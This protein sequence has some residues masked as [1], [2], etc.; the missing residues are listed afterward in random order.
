M[1]IVVVKV[2]RFNGGISDDV[3][4]QLNGVFTITRNFDIFSNKTR[5]T[6]YRDT[7]AADT[8]DGTS[9]TMTEFKT[10]NFGYDSSKLFAL[11]R[12]SSGSAL[13][14]ILE[15]SVPSGNWSLSGS[16]SQTTNGV[17][18]RQCFFPYRNYFY[19]L[20][21]SGAGTSQRADVWRYGSVASGARVLELTFGGADVLT[22]NDSSLSR[23]AQGFIG[24]D[25]NAYLPYE[26]KLARTNGTTVTAAVLTLPRDLT[27]KSGTNWSRYAALACAPGNGNDSSKIFFWDFVSDDVTDVVDVGRG[28]LNVLENIE[29]TLIG[30][31]DV[32]GTT[33]ISFERKIQIIA[34]SGGSPRV[35]H[36]KSYTAAF[37]V[38]IFKQKKGNKL[39]IVLYDGSTYGIYV[40][41]RR[42]ANSPIAVTFDRFISND[43]A[44]TAALNF[45]FVGD[46]LFAST[47]TSG[48][49]RQ[50]LNS[51]T[52]TATSVYES[53][54]LNAGEI[55]KLKQLKSVSL[56][57]VPLPAGAVI[58]LDVKVD[59]GS[60]KEVFS[61][62]TDGRYY[63][64]A[65]KLETTNREFDDGYEFEFRIKSTGLAEP[66]EFKP[67]FEVLDD[68]QEE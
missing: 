33:S 48:N 11:G 29:G 50:T 22:I 32:G 10:E 9:S 57:F 59:G 25:D 19:G 55:T 41:G 34:W 42:D 13:L 30:V 14:R 17:P 56:G 52:F 44:V 23:A 5:L 47:G 63:H 40:I 21:V 26:N 53:Q 6:P 43:T 2:D 20:K 39:Y 60:W 3:R 4:E 68:Q 62:S 7:A 16:A 24:I 36:E 31:L 38:P 49:I 65:T 54:K 12:R 58:T 28:D 51:A 45:F 27:I 66:I 15:R 61:E 18:A 67:V 1:K 46:F 8:V 37:E 35:L 64:E